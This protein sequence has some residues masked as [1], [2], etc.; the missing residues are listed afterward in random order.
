MKNLRVQWGWCKV[1]MYN[2]NGLRTETI[3]DYYIA[4]KS[5]FLVVK[6]FF[7]PSIVYVSLIIFVP[8]IKHKQH[9][10]SFKTRSLKSF[11][12]LFHQALHLY[13][14]FVTSEGVFQGHKYPLIYHPK[15]N[16]SRNYLSHKI[17]K[18][19]LN[20]CLFMW[21]YIK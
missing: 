3:Y 6:L 8:W 4:M 10:K 18:K 7:H 2:T 11:T 13:N 19:K 20:T 14:N 5:M 17:I 9:K 12:I 1:V 21:F 16:C 15:G